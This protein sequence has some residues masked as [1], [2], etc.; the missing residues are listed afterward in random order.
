MS[1][2]LRESITS[3]SA[4]WSP[5]V[6]A[7]I[8][9]IGGSVYWLAVQAWPTSV[10]VVLAMLATTLLMPAAKLSTR[11]FYLLLKYNALM[12]L[13]AAKLPF[14]APPN[15]ALGLIM[16]CG[17]SSSRALW[18]SAHSTGS[19]ASSR[20]T[21]LDVGIAMLLGFAPAA[22]LGIPGL[23]GLVVAIIIGIGFIAYSRR[24]RQVGA[25]TRVDRIQPMAEVSFYLGA[26][27]TWSYI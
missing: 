2:P 3:A 27:A 1:T 6:G 8:G 9:L 5:I 12:A 20:P 7:A 13:S 10:A 24:E 17:I 22:L 18:V 14:A 11:F 21:T 26:L 25:A 15:M 16:V 23:S 19:D 4:K